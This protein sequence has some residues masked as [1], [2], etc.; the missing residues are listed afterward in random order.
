MNT[1]LEFNNLQSAREYR[2][3]N[4]TGGWIFADEETGKAILFPP[5]FC[6]FAIFHHWITKGRTGE[7]VG[8]A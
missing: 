2:H 6:P 8:A 1:Y 4:G 5:E 7:L 3:A